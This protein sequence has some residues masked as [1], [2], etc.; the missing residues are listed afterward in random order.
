M[1]KL[2]KS[3]TNRSLHGVCGGIGEFFNISPT[4]IRLIFVFSPFPIPLVVYIFLANVM[5][6]SPEYI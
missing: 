5:P 3:A 4:L 2:T 6:E 1:K